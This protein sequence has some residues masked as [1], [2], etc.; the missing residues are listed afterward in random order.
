MSAMIRA[1]F[2]KTELFPKSYAKLMRSNDDWRGF[3]ASWRLRWLSAVREITPTRKWLYEL[4][5]DPDF[6]VTIPFSFIAEKYGVRVVLWCNLIP[7]IFMSIWA[8]TVGYFAHVLPTKAIIIGPF[9]AVFGGECVLQS[10]IFALTSA[11]AGEY[12]LR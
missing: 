9:L 6:L 3:K 8:I 10:T 7:R 1:S 11:L 12:V 4:I 5:R 2:H